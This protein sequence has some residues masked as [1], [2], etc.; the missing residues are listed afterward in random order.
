[1]RTQASYPECSWSSAFLCRRSPCSLGI[2]EG[3]I[4]TKHHRGLLL[5]KERLNCII[6]SEIKLR[7]RTILLRWHFKLTSIGG[8][9]PNS[10]IAGILTSSIKITWRWPGAGPSKTPL[11]LNIFMWIQER[12]YNETKT[13]FAIWWESSQFAL[14]FALNL[15]VQKTPWWQEHNP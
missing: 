4:R 15:F 8:W 1:M 2:D 14:E 9:A 11:A 10:S 5:L 7:M 13:R 3:A 6:Q 12:L